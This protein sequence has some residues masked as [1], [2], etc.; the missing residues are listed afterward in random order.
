MCVDSYLIKSFGLKTKWVSYFKVARF[1][2]KIP[3]YAA[4]CISLMAPFFF[5]MQ[6]IRS[7]Q[8]GRNQSVVTGNN[9]HCLFLSFT[10][11]PKIIEL[12]NKYGH[13]QPFKQC[14]SGRLLFFIQEMTTYEIAKSFF[15]SLEYSVRFLLSVH[16]RY[17]LHVTS[18]FELVAFNNY[19]ENLSR[20]NINE[21]TLTNHY[22]RWITLICEKGH[23]NVNII[24]HGLVV[25]D[26]L[27]KQKLQN[28]KSV[29][30]FNEE[31]LDIFCTNISAR[32]EF[33]RLLQKTN[34]NIS[35][36]DRCEV[37]IISNPFHLTEEL[38][39]YQELKK[40]S[41]DVKF[42]PH[43]LYINNEVLKIVEANDLCQGT[44]YPNPSYCLCKSSTLGYEY[45]SLGY[46]LISWNEEIDM[47]SILVL[48]KK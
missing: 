45:Q 3:T 10:H 31:Q 23:F 15:I 18:I 1:R 41:I 34:L 42:R 6:I 35:K 8:N 36:D 14:I 26:F 37:L 16:P 2:D 7:L 44:R 11:S 48:L 12:Y 33:T 4:I 46:K 32:P 20:N 43:P 30:G 17:F 19:L 39:I 28:V 21:V 27:P 24:Q 5:L 25:T 47:K 40:H 38:E 9:S 13:D 22:D 29:R